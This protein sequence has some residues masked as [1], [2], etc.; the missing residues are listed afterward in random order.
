[1][2]AAT[3]LK[4]VNYGLDISNPMNGRRQFYVRPAINQIVVAIR[5]IAPLFNIG[6]FGC[7]RVEGWIHQL[8]L[9]RLDGGEPPWRGK[10]IEVT[11]ACDGEC[12][13]SCE[14]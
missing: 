6:D 11:M 9:P 12:D 14:P 5:A 10:V 2:L 13:T 1:M 7:I 3:L 8:T 4:T